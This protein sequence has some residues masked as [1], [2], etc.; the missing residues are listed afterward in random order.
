VRGASGRQAVRDGALTEGLG[1][2]S[3]HSTVAIACAAILSPSL[4]GRWRVAGYALATPVGLSRVVVGAHLPLD[5][6]GG[7]A[8][9]LTLAYGWHAAVGVDMRAASRG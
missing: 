2:V 1:F 5:V 8:L 4:S 7:A 3:G 9:G 6:V